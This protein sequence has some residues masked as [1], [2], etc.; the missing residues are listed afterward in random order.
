VIL[1]D[2]FMSD[3]TSP[4]SQNI[5]NTAVTKA[6]S[7]TNVIV[8]DW[9]ALSG[10]GITIGNPIETAIAY[11]SVLQ[12]VGPV[13]GRVADFCKF[14]HTQ[15]GIG[16][17]KIYLVGHSLGA[18]ISGA[19]GRF[20][21]E[22]FGSRISRIS[23]LDPAGPM[24]SLQPDEGLRLDKTDAHFVDIYH[25]NRGTLGDSA[26]QTGTTNV[27]VNGGDGQPGCEEADEAG[28]KGYCSHS[29]AWRIFVASYFDDIHACP[30]VGLPC[31]CKTNCDSGCSTP[32]RIG[33]H[34]PT[35]ASGAFHLITTDSYQQWT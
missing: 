30:C 7:P 26:H 22:R 25:T 28:F 24:F 11:T 4:M 12:N 23:G 34:M 13:G 19:A 29:Y 1:T 16:P 15:K 9:G 18:H 2:G 31:Q 8:V 10:S 27:Y 14:L 17:D 21:Q 32:V 35:T 3:S 6:M 5:K 20:Y 33:V